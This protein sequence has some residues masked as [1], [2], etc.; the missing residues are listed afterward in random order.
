MPSGL[1]S[2]G[3]SEIL[4]QGEQHLSTQA[5]TQID[6]RSCQQHADHDQIQTAHAED[7]AKQQ[8]PD[9]ASIAL[10]QAEEQNRRRQRR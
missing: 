8:L 9:S 1:D 10:H 3:T 6:Q 7:V 2:D 5:Q 4:I